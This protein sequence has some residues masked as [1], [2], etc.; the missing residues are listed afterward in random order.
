[1]GRLLPVLVACALIAPACMGSGSEP[2]GRL[3]VVVSLGPGGSHPAVRQYTLT[4]GPAG[5]TMPDAEAACEALADYLKHRDDPGRICIGLVPRTP[6]AL[7]AG[8]F[9]G[10]RLHLQ[11]TPGSWCGT[12][13]TLMRDY[14]ILSTLPCSTTVFRYPNQHPYS[15]GIAPDRCLR[16]PG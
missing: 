7:V 6:S 4:C 12:S 2:S 15:K 11:I 8:T 13:D 1:M 5:G 14:W 3:S 16:N 9:A 10:R